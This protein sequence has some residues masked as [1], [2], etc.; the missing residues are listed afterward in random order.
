MRAENLHRPRILSQHN[1][2]PSPGHGHAPALER[3]VIANLECGF[4]HAVT[5]AFSSLGCCYSE[6]QRFSNKCFVFGLVHFTPSPKTLASR[7]TVGCIKTCI[8]R[9]F[10][11]FLPHA[12]PFL[13]PYLEFLPELTQHGQL[14]ISD[15]VHKLAP[16]IR[17]RT[18]W[19]CSGL[20]S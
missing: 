14:F 17:L 11:V 7:L 16:R 6:L 5:F 13:P 18:A 20:D 8:F 10:L 3:V 12:I 4:V 2:Q 1:A 19:V 9:L 15:G